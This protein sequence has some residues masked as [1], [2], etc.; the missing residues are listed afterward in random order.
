MKSQGLVF[1]SIL[2]K[3]YL[4]LL[5]IFAINKN[6]FP[7][8]LV[9]FLAIFCLINIFLSTPLL[10]QTSKYLA[11]SRTELLKVFQR[12]FSLRE[13]SFAVVLLYFSLDPLKEAFNVINILKCYDPYDYWHQAGYE[14]FALGNTIYVDIAFM[15][16]R[17][18]EKELEEELQKVV[19]HWRDFSPL[20]KIAAV[21]D[22]II[23]HLAY[24][25]TY[26][27]YS[28]Y[29]AFFERKA[30][31]Q[32]YALLAYKMLELLEIPSSLISG[33]AN[34]QPHLW[35]IV[36]LCC[37]SRCTFFHMDVTWDDPL[38]DGQHDYRYFLL[39]DE[40]ILR[41]HLVEE[42]CNLS[43]PLNFPTWKNQC[44]VGKPIPSIKINNQPNFASLNYQEAI[45][46]TLSLTNAEN[47]A[48]DYFVWVVAAEGEKI[49]FTVDR[50]W[51]LSPEPLPAYQGPLIEFKDLKLLD[52]PPGSLQPGFYY[53]NF[54]V[55]TNRN[56]QL[57]EEA[58]KDTFL[59][60]VTGK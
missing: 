12:A 43:A 22:W 1:S 20:E 50:G 6:I 11:T 41:D 36:P 16:T 33:Y 31:C 29:E 8:L 21:H 39:S 54:A 3:I 28:A 51:V 49:W 17:Q 9:H 57:D 2:R 18:E 58:S 59:L 47:V 56:G 32:G 46:L 45:Y 19:S 10:A 60:F 48:G 44:L 40:E 25:T 55:D 35:N 5:R 27:N 23:S 34:G 37:Q 7:K 38:P 15:T 13:E 53:I 4:N 52:L 30:V 14:V 42:N 24:D 26:S